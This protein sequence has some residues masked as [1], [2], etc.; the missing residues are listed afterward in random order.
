M[1]EN[2]KNQYSNNHFS[3]FDHQISWRIYPRK[4][5]LQMLLNVLTF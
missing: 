5:W 1:M 4:K 3:Q 2:F